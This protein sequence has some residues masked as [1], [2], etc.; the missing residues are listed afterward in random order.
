[1]RHVSRSVR[2]LAAVLAVCLLACSCGNRV[3]L[4]PFERAVHEEIDFVSLE[5]VR[6]DIDA[7]DAKIDDALAAA[8]QGDAQTTMTLYNEILHAI[9]ELDTMSGVA[10]I[11]YDLDLTDT[12]YEEENLLLSEQY[13]RIDNRM[14]ELTGA[15]LASP[16]AKAAREYWG[17]DFIERYE[18]NRKLNSP[19]IEA[20]SKQEDELVSAYQKASAEE[21]SVEHDGTEYTMDDLD[22][23][24]EEGMALYDEIQAK[25]NAVLGQ[26]YLDLIDV[27]RQIAD[28]LGYDS[29]IDYAYDLLGR[30]FTKEEAAAFS[31]DVEE[32]LSFV[33]IVGMVYSYTEPD[34][35]QETLDSVPLSEGFDYLE[36][37][38]RAEAFPETM[39]EAL[40]YMRR[41]RLYDFGGGANRMSAGYS[42]ELTQYD[43]P[44]MF[45][46]TDYYTDPS[47]L[48]HEFGHYHN[49]YCEEEMIWNDGI[50][51]DLAEV[52]S[53]GL[54]LLMFST[55]EEMYGEDA[56]WI[57]YDQL[58]NIIYSVLSGCAEDSFQQAVFEDP[59]MTLDEMNALHADLTERFMGY[60]DPYGWVDI[61]HHFETPFYYISYATSALSALEL[62]VDSLENREKVIKI[63]SEL[64]QY[65]ANADYRETLKS[66]GLSD[67]FD[68]DCVESI[69]MALHEELD[70]ENAYNTIAGA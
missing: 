17:E 60:T 41:N 69:A 56:E 64:T 3:R 42:T 32:W 5:Y 65:C 22:Y 16:F 12:F 1:M 25:R 39:S 31:Q 20:L 35:V 66:V 21:F 45:I 49:F 48:F 8:E 47:T 68:S 59:D 10:G 26:Y 29:Y 30:D 38:L 2:L 44:F 43:A 51:L 14:N 15:I 27:R 50:S 36:E 7:L 19:E 37:A 55:Y 33:G 58:V 61:H 11:R 6:P 40:E 28:K 23:S 24:T 46:N 18:I 67:P 70:I 63:Y 53:Q 4:D 9:N 62:W 13:T 34:S 52:H 57:E 54:E